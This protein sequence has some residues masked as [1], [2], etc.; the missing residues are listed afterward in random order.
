VVLA[1][2][3]DVPLGKTRVVL[4]RGIDVPSF[5]W[6]KQG[7]FLQGALML[8]WDVDLWINYMYNECFQ[9]YYRIAVH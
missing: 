5:L 4:A 7:W 2:G 3:I 8:V 9:Q 1:R 6:V